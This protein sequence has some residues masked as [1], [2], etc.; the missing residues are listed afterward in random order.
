MCEN[1]RKL[2]DVPIKIAKLIEQERKTPFIWTAGCYGYD[3]RDGLTKLVVRTERTGPSLVLHTV[4][5]LDQ[6]E[7]KPISSSKL[8]PLPDVL[9]C[10]YLICGTLPSIE[11]IDLRYPRRGEAW[12]IL[13]NNNTVTSGER[14]EFHGRSMLTACYKAALWAILINKGDI[15]RAEKIPYKKL[16]DVN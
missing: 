5:L 4:D 12:V 9:E 7:P 16:G 8:V 1:M 6:K 14:W 15:G 11:N 2:S 10:L 3:D 13:K